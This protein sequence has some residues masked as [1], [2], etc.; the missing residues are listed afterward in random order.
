MGGRGLRRWSGAILATTA[1]LLVPVAGGSRAAATPLP[2]LAPPPPITWSAC[3]SQAGYR[4]GTVMVPVDYEQ[5][6]GPTISVPVIEKPAA[7]PAASRGALLFNPGGPGESGVLIHPVLAALVPKQVSDDFDLVSFDERGTGA[8]DGLLCG[9][10][11]AAAASVEPLP[12]TPSGP[13]PASTLFRGLHAGCAA[14][15]PALLPR[16]DST[17]AAR[18][19]DRIRQALGVSKISYWGLS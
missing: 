16:L 12:A 2:A 10:S 19:M 14:A 15:A 11:P 18:D 13:L 17:D 8:S 5:P 9:P 7:D 6:K 3:P 4:C 1:S